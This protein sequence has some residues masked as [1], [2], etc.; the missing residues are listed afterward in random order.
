VQLTPI[1]TNTS[2]RT[3]SKQIQNQRYK[4][5]ITKQN[6]SRPF[7]QRRRRQRTL[8]QQQYLSTYEIRDPLLVVAVFSASDPVNRFLWR[9][10]AILLKPKKPKNKNKKLKKQI[11]VP[12]N[13]VEGTLWEIF[14]KKN[15]HISSKK[16]RK[17]P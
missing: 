7:P 13:I 12:S 2:C 9:K 14:K 1:T 3:A 17:S 10:L 6:K 15:R 4:K 16:T 11:Y 5:K 8:Q